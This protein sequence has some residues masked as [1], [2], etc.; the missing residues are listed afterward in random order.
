MKFTTENAATNEIATLIQALIQK[1]KISLQETDRYSVQAFLQ[2][3]DTFFVF[4]ICF[5]A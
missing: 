2:F 4:F 5:R 3:F 1:Q